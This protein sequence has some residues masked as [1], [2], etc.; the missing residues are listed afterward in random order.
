MLLTIEI[1]NKKIILEY[2]PDNGAGF[3]DDYFKKGEGYRIKQTFFVTKNESYGQEEGNIDS[4]KFI[5]GKLSGEYYKIYKR[6]LG[7]QFDVL[8]HKSYNIAVNSLIVNNNISIINKFENL[9]KQQ[10]VIG[11]DQTNAIPTKVFKNIIR[12]FPTKTEITHYIDSRVTNVLSQYL[13]GV[14]DSGNAFERYLENR[15]MIKPINSILSVK[16]YEF[17]KYQFVLKNLKKWLKTS[18]TYSEDDWQQQILEIILLLYPKYIRCFQKVKIKDFYANPKKAKNRFVDL[19]LIDSNG[20]IDVIEI[21]K[22]F[23][24][25]IITRSKY[26][27]N[28]TPLKELSGTIMQVEKY[29]F[30]LN[31]WGLSGEKALTAKYKND[32][33]SELSVKI[34]NPKGIVILGRDNGLS[35]G[36]KFDFEIIKRKYSNVID[37][38]TYDDLIKRLEN[39]L[40]KFQTK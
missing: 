21:K 16:H 18:N 4:K 27:D 8:F 7:T 32:L 17:K 11:G 25:C 5:I 38:I 24:N 35:S 31:K 12:S 15:N 3:I 13:E 37:I 9:A 20:N 6:V 36:Q 30:H 39:M 29:L 28:Y 10:I 19:M 34:T 22:P 26:R 23:D 1:E 2:A 14:K 40:E 33:P